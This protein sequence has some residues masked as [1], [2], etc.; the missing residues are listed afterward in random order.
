MTQPDALSTFARLLDLPDCIRL[1]DAFLAGRS[2]RT[3]AAYRADLEDFRCYTG[4]STA[5][6]A[7]K[8]LLDNPQD[9]ARVLVLLYQLD[10]SKRGLQPATINRHL[11]TLRS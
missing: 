4:A 9:L 10:M 11:A 5:A 3:L 1:V 6:Y 8:S 2:P 7:A